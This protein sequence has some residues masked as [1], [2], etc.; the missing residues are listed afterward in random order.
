MRAF[1]GQDTCP[2]TQIHKVSQICR[3]EAYFEHS[4]AG[5][6]LL[7][8]QKWRLSPDSANNK[9]Q[10][11]DRFP[12]P[13]RKLDQNKVIDNPPS[14][15]SFCAPSPPSFSLCL[16]SCHSIA[17]ALSHHFFLFLSQ[18][19]SISPHLSLLFSQSVCFLAQFYLFPLSSSLAQFYSSL[20]AL[21]KNLFY[22]SA[23][24]LFLSI[25]ECFFPTFL[26]N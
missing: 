15:A 9:A 10:P 16:Y 14:F 8:H 7:S 25:L 1:N 5:V 26:E 20:C 2:N 23:T 22:F 19:A 12:I 17:S 3:D 4:T 6:S 13:K 24:L 18:D 11:L 21:F